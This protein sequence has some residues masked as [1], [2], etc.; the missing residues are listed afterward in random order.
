[1]G[2][3]QLDAEVAFLAIVAV[4]ICTV[5]LNIIKLNLVQAAPCE[6]GVRV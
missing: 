5:R 1:M 2:L 6:Q 3:L 4:R